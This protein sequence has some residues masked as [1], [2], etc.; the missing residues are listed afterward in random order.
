MQEPAGQTWLQ[1]I[2]NYRSFGKPREMPAKREFDE[3]SHSE[4]QEA[5]LWG[6][7]GWA[8][9]PVIIALCLITPIFA[10][11]FMIGIVLSEVFNFSGSPFPKTFDADERML[12][13]P[14]ILIYATCIVIVILVNLYSGR[15]ARWLVHRWPRKFADTRGL[16]TYEYAKSVSRA[17]LKYGSVG[18]LFALIL[19]VYYLGL[20]ALPFFFGLGTPMILLAWFVY[21]GATRS[22]IDPCCRKCGYSLPL[23]DVMPERCSECGV[24]LTEPW[25]RVLGRSRRHGLW[26][27]YFGLLMLMPIAVGAAMQYFVP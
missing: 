13:Y 17:S 12:L 1:R 6:E 16:A 25:G 24:E 21:R 4:Q 10:T 19:I 14:V 3:L 5:M 18:I 7:R 8:G 26:W 9:I 20:T 27:V 11:G 23:N 15:P 22:G 2:L